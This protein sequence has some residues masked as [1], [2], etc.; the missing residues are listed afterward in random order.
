MNLLLRINDFPFIKK[1]DREIK[2]RR[3]DC[4]IGRLLVSLKD[5]Y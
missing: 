1:G 3:G 4:I 5:S 2:Y